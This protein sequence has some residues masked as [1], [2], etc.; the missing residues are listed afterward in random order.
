M[1]VS[2]VQALVGKSP[3]RLLTHFMFCRLLSLPDAIGR[4]TGLQ[5]LSVAENSLTAVPNTVGRL[6]KLRLLD[7]SSNRLTALPEVR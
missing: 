1:F 4:L 3:C 6:R 7:V 2:Q 5:Q